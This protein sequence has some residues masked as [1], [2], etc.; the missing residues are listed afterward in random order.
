MTALNVSNCLL[1]AVILCHK[2]VFTARKVYLPA[3]SDLLPHRGFSHSN[4]Y[5]KTHYCSV[6]RSAVLFPESTVSL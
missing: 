6:C 3:F 4:Q 5:F 1:R 2:I